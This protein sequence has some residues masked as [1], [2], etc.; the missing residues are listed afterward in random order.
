MSTW[1]R[2]RALWALLLATL[3]AAA[4]TARAAG[5]VMS[6][7]RGI[8]LLDDAGDFVRYLRAS[9][10]MP[11]AAPGGVVFTEDNQVWRMAADGTAAR[12]VTAFPGVALRPHQVGDLIVFQ[13]APWGVSA[14]GVWLVRADGTGLRQLVSSGAQPVLSPSGTWVAYTLETPAPGESPPYHREIWRVNTDGTGLAP[15]TFLGDPDYPDANAP[16][17]SPDDSRVAFFSG[18]EA[19]DASA[20]GMNPWSWGYRNVAVAPAAGG[21]RRNVTGCKPLSVDASAPC[22]TADNPAWSPDGYRLLVDLGVVNG[23][24]NGSVLIDIG[25]YHRI[26]PSPHGGGAAPWR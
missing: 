13:G 11:S 16:S 23:D 7:A 6:D 26:Y 25:G 9:G 14:F 21:A 22:V 8:F 5:F 4:T 1:L 20:T 3:L 17:I 15:L 10:G 18:R 24:Y 12:R 19:D 2:R